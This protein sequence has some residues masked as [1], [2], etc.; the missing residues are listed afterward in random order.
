MKRTVLFILNLLLALQGT[1]AVIVI[2]SETYDE[3]KV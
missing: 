2:T 3:W 1:V